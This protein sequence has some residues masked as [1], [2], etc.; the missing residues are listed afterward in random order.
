MKHGLHIMQIDREHGTT[1]VSDRRA[2]V[3]V[4][5]LVFRRTEIASE[6]TAFEH[7]AQLRIHRERVDELTVYLTPLLDE[8]LAVLFDDLGLDLTGLLVRELGDVA[9]AGDD[10]IS[11]FDHTVGAQGIGLP[12]P[13]QG[14]FRALVALRQRRRRPIGVN[15]RTVRNPRVHGL[16]RIPSDVGGSLGSLRERLP[17]DDDDLHRG[18]LSGCTKATNRPRR[19]TVPH[20]G[21]RSTE[22][23]SD[24]LEEN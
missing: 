12:G 2:A 23:R 18:C 6:V 13:P 24:W 20:P 15:G 5:V 21:T 3:V 11:D 16:E 4:E 10:C 19:L 17:H 7:T 9:L 1:A 8:D 22:R 14:R